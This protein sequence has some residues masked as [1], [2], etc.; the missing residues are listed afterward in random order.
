[1]N[2]YVYPR[3]D[4]KAELTLRKQNSRFLHY[5]VQWKSALD[6]GYPETDI[7]QGEFFLPRTGQKPPLAILVHGLGDYSV[8]PCKLLAASLLKK[9]FASF[10]PYLI[11]HSKRIPES[12]RERMPYLTPDEWF[13]TYQVSVVDILQIVDWVYTRE[14]LDSQRIVT[15]GISFGGGVSSIAMGI[16]NRIKAG[17]FIVSGGNQ[18]KMSW[19]SKDSSYREKYPRSEEEHL[20]IQ[21][22]YSEYLEKVSEHGFENVSTENN[23]FL[24]DPMTFAGKLKGRPI[25]MIN[26]LQ[27]KYFP[28]EAVIDFW[29]ALGEPPIRWIDSGHSSLWLHYPS[30]RRDIVDFLESN[31]IISNSDRQQGVTK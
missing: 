8:T 3:S 16:D 21:H 25:F 10:V 7:V 20:K 28:K 30:I 5:L 12:M 14:E 19:L 29:Q 23:S 31:S 24:T 18:N 2:P 26:A 27:D 13:K 11:I 15:M 1:M 17:V 22:S 6:T 9:G 4:Q